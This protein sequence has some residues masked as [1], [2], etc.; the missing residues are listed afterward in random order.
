MEN[1]FYVYI[2]KK[3]DDFGVFYVGKGCGRRAYW[4]NGRN[5]HWHYIVKKHGYIVEIVKNEMLESDAFSLEIELI[6]KYGKEN[7]CNYTDGGDGH[8]GHSPTIETRNKMRERMTGR[9]F[10][11]ETILKMSTHAKNRTEEHRRKISE[12]LRGRK[13]SDES[14]LKK[15]I[16]GMGRILTKE[17]RRKIS[18]YHIGK[19][20]K[21]EAVRKMAESKMIKVI[22]L[23][24]NTI[25]ESMRDAGRKLGITSNKIS[26]VCNGKLKSIKGFV[27]RK[28]END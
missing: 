24:N 19:K 8:A 20:K 9:V 1:R 2:H 13:Q 10:G 27:F 22:C 14:K 15:S 17:E 23:N 21:P 26:D 18:E 3:S 28:I 12:A 5:D 16:A 4:K 6:K 11:K 7:L 25:Y